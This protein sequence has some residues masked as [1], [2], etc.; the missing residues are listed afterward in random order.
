MIYLI[1]LQLKISSPKACK[2]VRIAKNVEEY[3]LFNKMSMSNYSE[4]TSHLS[5]LVSLIKQNTSM[6]IV[7]AA[8]PDE[9]F[10]AKKSCVFCV[11]R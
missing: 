1:A 8:T 7:V 6:K 3:F 9:N 10:P 4:C 2:H 11:R 5:V